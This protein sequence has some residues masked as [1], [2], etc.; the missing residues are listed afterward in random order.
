MAPAV[1]RGRRFKNMFI[2]ARS[3]KSIGEVRQ[4]FE[5]ASA[6]TEIMEEA[7]K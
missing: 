1:R 4:K 7:A 5:D 2:T 6:V 3:R